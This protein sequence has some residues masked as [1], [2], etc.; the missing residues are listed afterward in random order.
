MTCEKAL[1][2]KDVAYRREIPVRYDASVQNYSC[3]TAAFA[4]MLRDDVAAGLIPF[5]VTSTA[6][7]SSTCAY[8]DIA[9]INVLCK[10]YGLW[11]NIDAA[12]GGVFWA[13]PEVRARCTGI[14]TSTPY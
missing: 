4:R 12:F 8:D 9:A 7:S 10:Q 11:H 6:G 13:I 5:W 1:L 2:L 14:E 3:D